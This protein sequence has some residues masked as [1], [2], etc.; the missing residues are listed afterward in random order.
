MILTASF[1]RA[2]IYVDEGTQVIEYYC[3]KHIAYSMASAYAL[4]HLLQVVWFYLKI[5]LVKQIGKIALL[6]DSP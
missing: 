4:L 5:Y 6:N 2:K 1:S 3:V